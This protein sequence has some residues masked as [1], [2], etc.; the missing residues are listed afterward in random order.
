VGDLSLFGNDGNKMRIILTILMMTASGLLIHAQ[1]D[2]RG[3]AQK[4]KPP[5]CCTPFR[6][7]ADGETRGDGESP[8]YGTLEGNIP[9][10]LP[11]GTSG[12]V[13]RLSRYLLSLA[14]YRTVAERQRLLGKITTSEFNERMENYNER[15]EEYQQKLG[16]LDPEDRVTLLSLEIRIANRRIEELLRTLETLTTEK[17]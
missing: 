9:F 15:Y 3:S 17:P 11:T 4:P 5:P 2:P 1:S 13:D 14:D 12:P 6:T 16:K 8:R 7:T 10:S